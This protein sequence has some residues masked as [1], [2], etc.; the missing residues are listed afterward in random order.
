MGKRQGKLARFGFVALLVAMAQPGCMQIGK[1]VGGMIT[2]KT[3][4]LNEVAMQV[5]FIRNLY[6][7]DTKTTEAT[8]FPNDW[9]AGRNVVSVN[10]LKR[11]GVGMY[12]I[13]GQVNADGTPLTYAGN[14]AY[15]RFL[16]DVGPHTVSISTIKGQKAEVSV[17]PVEPVKLKAINGGSGKID[18][19]QDLTLEFELQNAAHTMM[20]AS[21]LMDIMGARDWVDI[22]QFKEKEKVVIPAAAFKNL[23]G[24]APTKGASFLRVER[25]HVFDQVVPGVGAAQVL[26]VAWDAKPVTVEG[27]FGTKIETIKAE[28]V[29]KSEGATKGHARDLHYD[30]S[31]PNAYT[32]RPFSTAKKF[33]LISL[34]VRATKLQ[35][36][37]STSTTTTAGNIQTTTTTTT[38]KTFPTLPPVFWDALV[39]NV[40]K[41]VIALFKKNYN[42]DIIPVED[43]LKAP[44]Y[45]TLEAIPEEHSV[46]EVERN[47]KG[48]RNLIPTSISGLF[49]SISSTF[50]SDRIDAR[51]IRELGVDGLVSVTLD[52]EMPWEEFSL[53]PR[54]AIRVSG[55]ANGY[56]HGPTIYAQG[57]VYGPGV[58]LDEAKLKAENKTVLKVLEDIVRRQDLIK[59]LAAGLEKLK[60]TEAEQHYPALWALQQ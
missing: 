19:S 29:V 24:V 60:A 51:L 32:G 31:K 40:A 35:Q 21:L 23:P 56:M 46:V 42:I 39:E 37:Q 30:L 59:T 43:V 16:D 34:S 10:F 52:L 4:D 48:T 3:A 33:A 1:M 38:T 12:A 13:D 26:S 57:V 2:A 55:P 17:E 11:Q 50:A 49:K 22:A 41:D 6:P 28:G 27:D 5:R 58:P 7:A 8:Y 47:Y 20:K 45:A 18:L 44:S 36:V 9:R 54:L 53:S 14:G 15:G 25:M